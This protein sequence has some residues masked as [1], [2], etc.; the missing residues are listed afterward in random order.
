MCG[1]KK[2]QTFKVAGSEIKEGGT[3]ECSE[4]LGKD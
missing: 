3:M 1:K 2:A 4:G